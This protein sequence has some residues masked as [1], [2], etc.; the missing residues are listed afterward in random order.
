MTFSPPWPS[1]IRKAALTVPVIVELT[2]ACRSSEP[3]TAPAPLAAHVFD[4]DSGSRFVLA[5]VVESAQSGEAVDLIL[6]DRRVR[7]PR[8]VAASGVHYTAGGVSVWNKGREATLEIDGRVSRCIE[9]RRRSLAE[10]ARARGVELRATGNEPGWTLELFSD[11][12]VLVEG[13]GAQ[14]TTVPRPPRR[15][16]STAAED[17]YVAEGQGRRRLIVRTRPG[18]CVDTMSG[19]RHAVTVDLEVDG[20]AY[21]GCGDT[22]AR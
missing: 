6:P 20:K 3:T 9:N 4:C 10:D 12:L 21:R 17:V 8:V 14:R 1:I 16:G 7:L 11:R 13:Y 22:L 18:V 5:R 2:T 15:T 19:D